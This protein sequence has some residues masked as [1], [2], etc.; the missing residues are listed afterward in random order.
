MDTARQIVRW[1]LPGWITFLF[2]GGFIIVGVLLHGDNQI[3]YQQLLHDINA[4][5]L[6]LGVISIPLGFITYQLYYWLYWY[7]PIPSIARK[8][9]VDP[10]DRGKE[11]L[12]GVKDVDFY[13]I[14]GSSINDDTPKTAFRKWG[15]IYY[16]S[17]E[18]MRKYRENWHLSDSVWYLALADDRYKN[19]AGFLEKRNQF[20]GDIYHS[21][22]AC[23][24]GLIIAYSG[25]LFTAIYV[26]YS[27]L[28]VINTGDFNRAIILRVVS[29]FINSIILIVVSRIFK[30]GRMASFEALL[31][32]KHDVITNVLLDRPVNK[33]GTD[34]KKPE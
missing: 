33:K 32:L 9:F 1:A 30:G 11:I 5:L 13:K 18:V 3:M 29:L 28:N 4:L 26:L 7:V 23:G 27:E 21:L 24:I 34:N 8:K 19:T 22:G 14:F 25:Y 12:S 20:L 2:W 17:I 15:F 10:L 6:L 16:K 31:Q